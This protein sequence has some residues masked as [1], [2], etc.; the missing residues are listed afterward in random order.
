MSTTTI[1]DPQITCH[2]NGGGGGDGVDT[3]IELTDTPSGYGGQA[4][5]TVVVNPTGTGLTFTDSAG[6]GGTNNIF[7]INAGQE[8][9]VVEN[10]ELVSTGLFYLDGQ[11]NLNGKWCLLGEAVSL[12]GSSFGSGDGDD[13]THSD[14]LVLADLDL[15][16]DG[17]GGYCQ[18]VYH[19]LQGFPLLK[20]LASDQREI[21]PHIRHVSIGHF[22]VE[23]NIPLTGKI[24][25]L[26]STQTRVP[27]LFGALNL[28]AIG[29]QY[30]QVL[31]HNANSF[32]FFKIMDGFG[33]ELQLEVQHINNQTTKILSNVLVT[34]QIYML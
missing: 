24:Y 25:A 31:T 7:K 8:Y 22:V 15:L 26:H 1:F 14:L 6:G 30:E 34:G 12:A 5:K 23:S 3:F 10:Q 21:D 13:H 18:H 4:N 11:M 29:N 9:T 33:T 28:Q 17:Y 16:P 32:P 2:E 27:V 19:T 20:F